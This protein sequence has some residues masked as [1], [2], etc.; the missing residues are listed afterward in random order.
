MSRVE[1]RR[2]KTD[3]VE[4]GGAAT[5]APA[6]LLGHVEDPAPQ[7]GGPMRFGKV[8]D[9]KEQHAERGTPRHPAEQ[10]VGCRI[11]GDD[12]QGVAVLEAGDGLVESSRPSESSSS[13][14]CVG[15]S[16]TTMMGSVM[17]ARL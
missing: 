1:A 2:L 6:F 12:G 10:R 3:R 14:F 15:A 4:N 11:P 9:I 8:E 7:P 5:A 16:V 13:T 17:L